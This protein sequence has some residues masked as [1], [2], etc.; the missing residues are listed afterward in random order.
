MYHENLC[1]IKDIDLIKQCL[2]EKRILITHDNDFKNP[3]LYPKG[4][5]YGIIILKS[6]KQGKMAVKNFFERFLKIFSLD[7]AKGKIIIVEGSQIRIR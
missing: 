7:E 1:G 6:I 3:F 2:K 5:F 4:S